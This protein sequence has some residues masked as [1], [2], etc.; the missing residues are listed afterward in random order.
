MDFINEFLKNAKEIGK[1]NSSTLELYRKDIEDFDGFIVGKE[2]LDVNNEDIVR[3]IEELKK[4]YSDMSIYRK[5]SSLKSFYKYLLKTRIIDEYPIKDI[6]LPSRVKKS[7]KA[8][9]KWELK[10]ILDICNDTYEERRDSLVIRLLYET[11]LK[12]G[13]ILSL[14]RSDLEKYEYRIINVRSASKIIN[15]KISDELSR[16]LREF[17]EKLLPNMY[18][19][20]NKVFEEL[21]R[22]SFR[23]RFIGY[24]K[25][26][27]LEREISPNMIKKIIVEEKTRD[28]DGL[29]FIDKIREQYMRI[30]IGDD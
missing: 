3:Y 28:E 13:D 22:E 6:E 5:I 10:R 23:V 4:K 11:G 16:D 24:G 7:T 14:E 2:L 25:R 12:I 19:N 27:E 1:I 29:S 8:L 20:R 26:A 18:M 9:E 30:G 17:V 15:E 21:S